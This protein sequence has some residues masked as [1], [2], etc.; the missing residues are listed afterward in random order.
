MGD[1]ESFDAMLDAGSATPLPSN[2]E[3]VVFLKVMVPSEKRKHI[4]GT[5]RQ[6]VHPLYAGFQRHLRLE[7]IWEPLGNIFQNLQTNIPP[8]NA[9]LLYQAVSVAPIE[10]KRMM[11]DARRS[12]F[13]TFYDAEAVTYRQNDETKVAKRYIKVDLRELRQP[14]KCLLLVVYEQGNRD[15]TFHTERLVE[16]VAVFVGGRERGRFSTMPPSSML[17]NYY[18]YLAEL[19]SVNNILLIEQ[20]L[21][22]LGSNKDV[23]ASPER[24]DFYSDAEIHVKIRDEVL[25]AEL[26]NPGYVIKVFA[27]CYDS[28]VIKDGDM[29]TSFT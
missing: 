29:G 6:H 19:R 22:C 12:V 20:D 8:P 5:S 16:N 24:Y 15:F 26:T 1:D 18:G 27:V 4:G 7:V 21:F 13:E 2:K 3:H 28:Y 10:R 23:I 25:D 11:M 9:S 17:M 14:V